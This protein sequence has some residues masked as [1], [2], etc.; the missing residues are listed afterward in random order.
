MKEPDMASLRC[1]I[2]ARLPCH[3][4]EISTQLRKLANQFPPSRNNILSYS[5]RL[6]A[7]ST[8]FLLLFPIMNSLP[9]KDL[10]IVRHH[11]GPC[12]RFLNKLNGLQELLALCARNSTTRPAVLVSGKWISPLGEDAHRCFQEALS[13]IDASINRAVYSMRESFKCGG[14]LCSELEVLFEWVA[15]SLQVSFNHLGANDTVLLQDCLGF[16]YEEITVQTD[17]AFSAQDSSP[18]FI[19]KPLTSLFGIR[20]LQIQ[21]LTTL[22]LSPVLS[23]FPDL[24][25]LSW[26]KNGEP[27]ALIIPSVKGYDATL[28]VSSFDD[29]LEIESHYQATFPESLLDYTWDK[30]AQGSAGRLVL[31]KTLLT[32]HDNGRPKEREVLLFQHKLLFLRNKGDFKMV[33]WDISLWKDVILIAYNPIGR[34]RRAKD[35]SMESGSLTVYW[36]MEM[37]GKPRVSA[38]QLYFDDPWSL[39]LWAAFLALDPEMP[40]QIPLK[41]QNRSTF[42]K[43]HLLNGNR[44]LTS[45]FQCHLCRNLVCL[46]LSRIPQPARMELLLVFGL[47][48]HVLKNL[49]RT[50]RASP[51]LAY[52]GTAHPENSRKRTRSFGDYLDFAT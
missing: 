44:T 5:E 46:D 10:I 3:A 23:N 15:K 29:L 52:S 16:S 41:R 48:S 31:H 30:E 4:C 21:P 6:E 19:R 1:Q 8:N 25:S 36:K 40:E 35:T 24:R 51:H 13:N 12:Q 26:I 49:A 42:Q 37:A 18:S 47:R 27:E 14:V 33:I 22:P 11:L 43:H 20:A 9:N 39:Q 17:A 38:V 32:S 28:D 45:N 7:M 50:W 2:N 34:L